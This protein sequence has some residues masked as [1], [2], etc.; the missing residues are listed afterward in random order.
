MD[1]IRNNGNKILGEPNNRVD[2]AS[3]YARSINPAA[4]R[5]DSRTGSPLDV[6]EC[7]SELHLVPSRWDRSGWRYVQKDP[8]DSKFFQS[9]NRVNNFGVNGDRKRVVNNGRESFYKSANK[10]AFG[11]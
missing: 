10:S 1:A 6:R 2:A 5:M 8:A 7:D 11:N 9:P 3:T 4:A